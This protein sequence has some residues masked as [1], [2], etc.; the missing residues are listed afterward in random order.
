MTDLITRTY[1]NDTEKGY[2]R[3]VSTANNSFN[4]ERQLTFLIYQMFIKNLWPYLVIIFR[5]V[6]EENMNL[7]HV[8]RYNV[9]LGTDKSAILMFIASQDSDLNYKDGIS[10]ESKVKK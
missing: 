5:F 2:P 1:N 4:F 10:R 3:F 8:L 7:G 6:L 9:L